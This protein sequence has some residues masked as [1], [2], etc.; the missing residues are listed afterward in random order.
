M[1]WY[2]K[3]KQARIERGLS[4]QK[5]ADSLGLTRGC[6]SNYELGTR[7]PPIDTLRKMCELFEIS[8]DYLIGLSDDY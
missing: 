3:L 4:Q 7:E 5:V 8:A 1:E 6:Y 2:D